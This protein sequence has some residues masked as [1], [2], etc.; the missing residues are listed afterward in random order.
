MK[1]FTRLIRHDSVVVAF[2][3]VTDEIG[4]RTPEAKSFEMRK[5]THGV[6]A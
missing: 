1:L 3:I 4:V 5:S 6:E 2:T